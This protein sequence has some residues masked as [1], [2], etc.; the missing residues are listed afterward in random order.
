MTSSKSPLVSLFRIVRSKKALNKKQLF[1][2]V[3]EMYIHT[4]EIF[5]SGHFGDNP[6]PE[7]EKV[8]S[9][10]EDWP[11]GWEGRRQLK[12]GV[13]YIVIHF[14]EEED[15]SKVSNAANAFFYDVFEQAGLLNDYVYSIKRV[16]NKT[17]VHALLNRYDVLGEGPFWFPKEGYFSLENIRK[18]LAEKATESGMP[19]IT[20]LSRT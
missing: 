13:F 11:S 17:E 3:D 6:N 12:T 10:V 8:Y 20:G 14:G 18:V 5:G 7:I 19:M 4:R 1:K 2:L 9:C 15:L 16:Q